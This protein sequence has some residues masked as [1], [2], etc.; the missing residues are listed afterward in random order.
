[1]WAVV[2]R[3][4]KSESRNAFTYWLRVA[5]AGTLLAAGFG[6]LS[7]SGSL[8]AGAQIFSEL[9]TYVFG[10]IWILVP[11]ATSDVISRERREGT[12]GLL[13]LTPL[14]SPGI[15]MGK[16]FAHMLRFLT[17]LFATL[18][19]L[20]IPIVLGGVTWQSASRTALLH[21]TALSWAIAASLMASSLCKRLFSALFL[22]LILNAVY[23]AVFYASISLG[24]K[25]VALNSFLCLFISF[26]V[27]IANSDKSTLD[28]PISL[29]KEIFRKE[30]CTPSVG[31]GVFKKWMRWRLENNPVGWLEQRTV[32]GRMATWGWLGLI[33]VFYCLFTPT[34]TLRWPPFQIAQLMVLLL[35]LGSLGL[36]AAASFRRERENGVLELL[37]ITPL[38]VRQILAGR[39]FG[40]W[41]QFLPGTALLFGCWIYLFEGLGRIISP[42]ET[43]GW[44]L[45]NLAM[46][47][48]AF[49]GLPIVGLYFSL[50]LKHLLTAFLATLAVGIITPLSLTY[51]VWYALEQSG[52]S[53]DNFMPEKYRDYCYD[54][55]AIG[56]QIVI[57]SLF[58]RRLHRSLVHRLFA[59]ERTGAT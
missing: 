11:L 6:S 43:M 48:V 33:V 51:A 54:A 15:I 39:L 35:L 5:G 22:A 25:A 49:V 27:A 17:V 44:L 21:L 38:A 26:G 30:L 57:A 55:L 2:E 3:E 37:L 58:L 53:L 46:A 16:A 36:C 8:Q 13:Y 32:S 47:A 42:E 28:P 20:A 50:R 23:A 9:G 52:L 24:P 7:A 40:I 18:P 29:D 59:L 4:L 12:L 1:M 41:I 31:V 14:T 56:L 34:L 19:V 45:G 10:G